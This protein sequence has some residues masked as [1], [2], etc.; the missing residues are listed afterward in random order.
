MDNLLAASDVITLHVPALPQTEH[1]LD[2]AA[3]ACM[4]QGAVVIDTARGNIIDSRALIE[5]LR[6][7]KIAAAGLDVLPDEPLIREEAELISSI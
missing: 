2:D 5:A 1:L 4:T 7:G 6:G 3:F